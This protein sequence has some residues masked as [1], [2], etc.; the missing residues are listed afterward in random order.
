MER[1]AS[2]LQP[3]KTKRRRRRQKD[4]KLCSLSLSFI[5]IPCVEIDYDIY[6]MHP[7][8]FGMKTGNAVGGGNKHKQSDLVGKISE[9][10]AKEQRQLGNALP[11]WV[12]R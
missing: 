1:F 4:T 5:L 11:E 9:L 10:G 6:I 3:G 2:I 8:T 12:R 7:Y